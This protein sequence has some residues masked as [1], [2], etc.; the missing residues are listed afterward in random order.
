MI[1][2]IILNALFL[3]FP[4][5]Q[6]H[7]QNFEIKSPDKKITLT[8]KV[9]NSI[10]WPASFHENIVMKTANVGMDFSSGPDFG[11]NTKLAVLFS[12]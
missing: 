8:N 1:K 7:A 9:N 5:R 10:S 11:V 12:G 2:L 3:I 4:G 6:T